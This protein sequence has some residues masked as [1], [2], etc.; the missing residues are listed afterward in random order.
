MRPADRTTGG[1]TATRPVFSRAA[2]REGPPAA[3]SRHPT[4]ST[5]HRSTWRPGSGKVALVLGDASLGCNGGS[6]PCSPDALERIVDLVGY[7]TGLS[8][9]ANF[10]E[11]PRRHR[12]ISQFL[13]AFRADGGCTDTDDNGDDFSTAT[14]APRNT[15]S[16]LNSCAAPVTL[17]IADVSLAEGDTGTTDGN[18]H[19]Q[20]QRS[21]AGGR[22]RG[23]RSRPRTA[24]PRR[25]AATTGEQPLGPGR[26][27]KVTR[28]TPSTS[29]FTATSTLKRMKRSLSR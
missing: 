14:P 6:T 25:R 13:A 18:L 24:R 9:G 17:S 7:G 3:L 22:R 5:R 29:R 11:G 10:F 4:T 26:S 1:H 27:P 19:G 28:A 23:S 12:C 8:T 15:A 21:G 20:P 2:G 16:E